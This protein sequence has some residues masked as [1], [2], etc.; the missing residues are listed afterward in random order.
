[1]LP[2]QPRE[3]VGSVPASVSLTTPGLWLTGVERWLLL[4]GLALALGGLA[5][6]AV[7]RQYLARRARE[8]LPGGPAPLPSPWALRGSLLGVLGSAALLVTE[9]ADPGLAA[10]LAR[11]P[12]AG[13]ESSAPTAIAI[14]E[15]ACF[16]VAALLLRFRQSRWSVLPLLGVVVAEGIRAHPEGIIPAAGAA[17]TYCHLLPAVTW[18]GMLFYTLR[19]AAAWRSDPVAMQG[20]V[21]VYAAAAAWLLS[22]VVVTGL[23]SALLLVPVSSLL[24]TTYGR[25]LIAKAVIVAV[26]VGCAI[27]GRI[28]LHRR[29]LPGAGP[30]LATKLE[31]TGLAVVLAVTSL[32]TALTPPAKAIYGRSAQTGISQQRRAGEVQSAPEPGRAGSVSAPAGPGKWV[33]Q[34]VRQPGRAGPVSATVGPARG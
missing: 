25:F 14:A 33:S 16:A 32:L 6:R 17:L 5:G 2:I 28:W 19:A 30:A 8:G 9:R 21:R 27:A 24:T 23:I 3:A 4:A 18:A 26:T 29:V 12:V 22:V 7:A 1:M 31:C 11:P 15:L 10:R 34:P 20:L 13:L